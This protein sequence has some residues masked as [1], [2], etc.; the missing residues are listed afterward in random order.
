MVHNQCINILHS[1]FPA[2]L[3][4]NHHDPI[5]LH[6][7]LISQINFCINLSGCIEDWYVQA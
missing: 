2:L 6:V 7:K 3:K 1:V 5:G 4:V